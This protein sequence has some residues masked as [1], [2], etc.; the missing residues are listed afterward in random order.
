MNKL[1]NI[2]IG[3]AA[4]FA[5]FAVVLTACTL[6]GHFLQSF[7]WIANTFKPEIPSPLLQNT[8]IGLVAVVGVGYVVALIILMG[9]L[10][11]L[12][13]ARLRGKFEE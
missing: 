2:A 8:F 4:C 7:E 6:L 13:G 3:A 9:K 11:E 12:L 10:C 1:V 5:G